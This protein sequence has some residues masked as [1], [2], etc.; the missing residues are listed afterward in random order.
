MIRP[1]A[2]LNSFYTLIKTHAE[3]YLISICLDFSVVDRSSVDNNELY[4][5]YKTYTSLNIVKHVN[6]KALTLYRV[7]HLQ[8]NGG[9]L[10][11]KMD[12]SYVTSIN[13][14]SRH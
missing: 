2:K 5:N 13:K 3:K 12:E 10:R 14:Q 4:I 11:K 7:A 1:L 8:S 9:T 6:V